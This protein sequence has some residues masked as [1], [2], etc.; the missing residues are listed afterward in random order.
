MIYFIATGGT[1]AMRRS[2]AAGGN[3]PA[4]SGKELLELAGD[5]P[6]MEQVEIDEWERL[7]GVHRDQ[8]ALWAMR[9][10]VRDVVS[11]PDPPAG[12]V[13]THGT[14]TLEETSYLLARTVEP[15]VPVV[16]TGAM[17][18][19]SDADWDGPR[20]LRDAF[21]VA[22]H[23]ESRGRGTMVVFAGRILDGLYATK[24]DSS[25]VDAFGE[26]GKSVGV[27]RSVGREVGKSV[28]V[29][30]SVGC[31]VGD[32]VIFHEPPAPRPVT[33][34]PQN[35]SAEVPI[36]PFVLGDR[37]QLLAA[38]FDYAD[39]VVI[40]GFGRG[41]CPPG[42]LPAVQKWLAAGRPVVLS[43]RCPFGEVGGEYAFDGGGGQLLRM[44]V[45]PAGARNSSLARME[46]V[47]SLGAEVPYGTA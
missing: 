38:A 6:G 47:I 33:L 45:I 34:F 41:N 24:L 9:N 44:G 11:R 42:V 40:E 23:P 1:I 36:V 2:A 15:E 20:N 12:I 7:P 29:G 14:D 21:L 43:T 18:T 16:V 22:A 4:L 26:V 8:A 27:G 35:L 32:R 31:V 25:S 17:H 39:G 37:G 19:S 28:E 13:I 5:L 46:L 30:R 3:V 10:R